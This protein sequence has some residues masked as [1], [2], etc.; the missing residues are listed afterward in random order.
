MRSSTRL[1]KVAVTTSLEDPRTDFEVNLL[2]TLNVLEA[3]RLSKS[4]PRVLFC[5]TNKVY[6]NNVNRIPVRE[7]GS[8]YVVSEP[9]CAK[10]IPTDFP[11]DS[12]KHT[13]YGVSKLPADL[14]VQ[15]YAHTYGLKT[16]TFSMS[17]IYGEGQSGNE[18]Q[19]W[20]A[21]FTLSMLRDKLLTIF[22]DGSH[23]GR[24]SL[25]H[26]ENGVPT[27]RDAEN[28]VMSPQP[29]PPETLHS[30]LLARPFRRFLVE[31]QAPPKAI[32]PHDG[33]P[34]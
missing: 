28:L 24:P 27:G 33:L 4:D 25:P 1:V 5:S 15:D 20:V 26:A 18:D 22:G 34:I 7:E 13:P 14:Y 30:W 31:W 2:G 12:C 23:W 21:H 17:C 32:F 19:G 29:G 9:A 3:A 8:R 10:G 16:D 6:G 11:I